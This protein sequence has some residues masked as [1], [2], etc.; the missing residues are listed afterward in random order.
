MIF[1]D[2]LW[3]PLALLMCLPLLA[4]EAPDIT[5]LVDTGNAAYLK[6]DYEGARQAYLQAW[7]AL[8]QT[9]PENPQRYDVLKRLTSVRAAAGEFADANNYLQMAIN[10][11]EQV[12]GPADP[13][14]AADLLQ[15]VGLFRSMGNFDQALVVLNRV[16]VLHSRGPNGFE[17][18]DVAD[19]FSRMAQIY[20]QKK[21]MDTAVDYLTRAL[22][23]RTKLAGPLDPS[24][25]YDLDRLGGVYTTQRDYPNAE[26]AY[27]HALVI[28][29]SLYG[30]NDADLIATVDGLAYACF[31]QKK[32]DEAEVLYQRLLDLWSA[33]VGKDHPMV[34]LALDKV[35]VFYATQKKFDQAKAA[36]DQANAIRAK[37]LAEGLSEQATEQFSEG[38]KDE[39]MALYKRAIRALDPPDPQYDELRTELQGMLKTVASLTPKMLVKKTPAPARK[40]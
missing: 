38:N 34:A 26:A 19:D 12:N 28:R 29:E 8:Q 18:T 27:R 25:V 10:W 15:S 36:A 39:T 7:D 9:P 1:R 22:E 6:G 33:S 14:I 3:L 20:L 2:G 37:F 16:V 21:S 23:M 5:N 17:C 11:R 4:Q 32:Y 24:L 31:G 40:K 13:K 30:K 35:A